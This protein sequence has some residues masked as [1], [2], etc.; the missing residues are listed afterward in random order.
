MVFQLLDEQFYKEMLLQ[1]QEN[2]KGLIQLVMDG[3][4]TRLD[5]IIRDLQDL[6]ITLEFT[7]DKGDET[8]GGI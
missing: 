4:N 8:R 7:Q 6:K 5:G 1:Q 3:T 2:F